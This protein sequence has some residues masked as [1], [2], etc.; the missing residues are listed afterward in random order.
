MSKFQTLD[1][2]LDHAIEHEIDVGF[3]DGAN[4][5][6]H[7]SAALIKRAA[8]RTLGVLQDENLGR[9]DHLILFVDDTLRFVQFFWAAI[10]G[11]IV[12]VPLAA[13]TGRAERDKLLA[14]WH[15]LDQPRVVA[16]VEQIATIRARLEESGDLETAR[17]LVATTIADQP[18]ASACEAEPVASDPDD[19]ALIQFSSGSTAAPKGVE[20]THANV[21]A[22]IHAINIASGFKADD[23][24]LSWMPLTHDMGL[25]GFHL[26]F[27]C[28]GHH[29]YL[30]RPDLFARR[31]RLWLDKAAEKRATILCA[32]NFGYRHTLRAINA[33]GVPDI[34][35]SAVR[36]I[37]NGAEPIVPALA[38]DFAAELAPTGL[39]VNALFPVYGLAEASLAVAFPAP[40]TGLG[41]VWVDRR[42]LGVGETAEHVD[43]MSEH[44]VELA[45]L[46]RSV[47]NT[48]L[49]LA[50]DD[51]KPVTPGTVG[52]VLIRGDNVTGG[53]YDAPEANA[54]ALRAD[55][56]LD[57]GD[58][59]FECDGDLVITGRA[60]EIIFLNGQNLYPQDL[61]TLAGD[62][63]GI[64]ADRV[65][66][67]GVN[68]AGIDGDA[69]VLF[70]VHRG[71]AADFVDT[72]RALAA[73]LNEAAGVSVFRV[74]PINRLPK[75]TSGKIQR[76]QL[77]ASLEAGE[78]DAVIAELDEMMPVA[79]ENTTDSGGDDAASRLLAICH[80][81]A[82]DKQVG[83]ADNLFEIGLSSLELAQI[84][85]GIESDW[86]GR[87][88]ITDLFDYPTV[89][90]LAAVLGQ[91]D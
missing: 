78:F 20:L 3:I 49:L 38:R 27:L 25:I 22:N 43:E 28:L 34:D 24:A 18:P 47:G 60:K 10:R 68:A 8:D 30:M 31:P 69:L 40:G 32:P 36:L 89:N 81:V 45:R 64:Q 16:D 2:G 61:E 42:R 5:E 50:G 23:V 83:P 14:I 67:V 11:G 70:A 66:A 44:S 41:T 75:T 37:Y 80:E 29:H 53:Y 79:D 26:T 73:K 15:K 82:P 54:A 48:D 55:G 39:A 58:L 88:E 77:A 72:A 46:G 86:P 17:R 59:G 1:G 7:Q 65:A 56:W 51:G 9:G 52:H 35:L 13:G 33:R 90:D 21:V 74:L 4:D 87:L 85:E 12:P 57:T 91:A 19:V 62:T 76:S 84:H 71:S 6:R 63:A